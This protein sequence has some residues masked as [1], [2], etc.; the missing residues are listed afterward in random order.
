M[1]ETRHGLESNLVPTSFFSFI[2]QHCPLGTKKDVW[3]RLCIYTVH[4]HTPAVL[5]RVLQ[6]K[7]H[8]TQ[9]ECFVVVI[10]HLLYIIMAYNTH[11]MQTVKYYY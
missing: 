4:R 10:V 8:L 11:I 6:S 2:A 9:A 7:A 1:M 3:T 5:T